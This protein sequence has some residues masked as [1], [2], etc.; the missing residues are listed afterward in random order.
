MPLKTS[1]GRSNSGFIDFIEKSGLSFRKVVG[2][3]DLSAF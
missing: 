2:E 3:A 1:S